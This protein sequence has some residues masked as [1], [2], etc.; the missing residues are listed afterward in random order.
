VKLI[1]PC[2]RPSGIIE[3][4]VEALTIDVSQKY[5]G[6]IIQ[7]LQTRGAELKDMVYTFGVFLLYLSPPHYDSTTLGTK[8]AVSSLLRL[9]VTCSAFVRKPKSPQ[10]EKPLS[11]QLFWVAALLLDNICFLRFV[12][13]FR[14]LAAQEAPKHKSNKGKLYACCDGRATAHAIQDLEARGWL[15]LFFSFSSHIRCF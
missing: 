7:A 6:F 1:L 13:E 15:D 10:A 3:E 5:T 9:R 4:P 2:I 12:Q 8:A 11:I 14:P